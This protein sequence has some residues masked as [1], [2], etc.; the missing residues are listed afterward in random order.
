MY[1]EPLM[2]SSAAFSNQ[3]ARAQTSVPPTPLQKPDRHGLATRLMSIRKFR[4]R[5]TGLHFQ[6][7][8]QKAFLSAPSLGHTQSVF[9][10]LFSLQSRIPDS[11]LH[12]PA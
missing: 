7:H 12:P 8:L 3:L 2:N 11:L 1:E 10:G 6:I 9:A 4:R 5:P